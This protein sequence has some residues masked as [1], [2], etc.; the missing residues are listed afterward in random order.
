M[1][2]YTII[3]AV[4]EI[5]KHFQIQQEPVF[6][7]LKHTW[8]TRTGLFSPNLIIGTSWS[9]HF[10]HNALPQWRQWCVLWVSEKPEENID[11]SEFLVISSFITFAAFLTAV[12]L[13]PRG[14]L[15]QLIQQSGQQLFARHLIVK[16]GHPFAVF[17]SQ[18]RIS[19]DQ[20]P[21]FSPN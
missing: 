2:L 15:S 18:T 7:T 11:L 9:L 12:S 6:K 16:N 3:K 21:R 5:N 17:S 10:E 20:N 13:R 1:S 4:T 8:H 14:G 19:F